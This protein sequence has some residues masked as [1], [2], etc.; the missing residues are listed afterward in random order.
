MLKY[1]FYLQFYMAK[2]LFIWPFSSQQRAL[3]LKKNK[4]VD[5]SPSNGETCGILPELVSEAAW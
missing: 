2:E 1:I 5:I 3:S 4:Y